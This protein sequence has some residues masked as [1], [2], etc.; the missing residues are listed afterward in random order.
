M[1]THIHRQNRPLAFTL[2][3][4]LVVIAIIAILA[5]MLL[6]ALA[7]AKQK[8][9]AIK[10]VNNLKQI[11]LANYMY[12]S[13]EGKPIEYSPWPHLWMSNLLVKYSAI[14]KVRTCPTAPERSAADLRRDRSGGGTTIRT[15][16]VEDNPARSYQGS[17]AING[18]FYSKDMYNWDA[19]GQRKHFKSESEVTNPSLS[20]YFADSV[21]V[22]TWPEPSD[23]PARNLFTGDNFAGAMLRVAIP[24][25]SFNASAAPRNFD[26][27][28]LL[29]G[30][31]NVG[32]ADN[33]VETVKLENLWNLEWHREWVR[34]AKRPGL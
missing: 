21:W 19:V 1:R 22:D 25:H 24:R 31:V 14:E 4:L 28:N 7:K 17:Y 20:P 5:G 32:F 13:D 30:A 16:I 8:G 11:G 27:K 34:P 12:F 29:P 10:C 23:R 3:E 26:P 6:P 18:W 9:H 33:H 2:I 15:W